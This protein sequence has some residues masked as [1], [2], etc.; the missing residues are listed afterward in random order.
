M[1]QASFVP[2]FIG[3]M[4]AAV[5]RRIIRKFYRY[6]ALN[7]AHALSIEELG[8]RRNNLFNRLIQR[9]VIIESSQGRFYL[10]EENYMR[11]RKDRLL[12]VLIAIVLVFIALVLTDILT[13][14]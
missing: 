7:P 3:F 5:I 13:H 12:I 10:D 2:V 8:L 6:N 14:S 9:R 1:Y 4:V 11:F